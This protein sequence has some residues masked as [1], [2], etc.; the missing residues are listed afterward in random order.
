M[1]S[2]RFWPVLAAA[3][4][5]GS[6]FA[7]WP[8]A[9]GANSGGPAQSP[10][11]T[12]APVQPAVPHSAPNW[13]PP[14]PIA[15]AAASGAWTSLGP[16]PGVD[17]NAG[18]P[19]SNSSGRVTSIAV[20]PTSG[21]QTVFAG[22]AGGGVWK[23]TN[24][25]TSW[26][27]LTDTQ[28][29]MAI[30]ALAIDAT[31]QELFAGTGE[32]NFN[33]DALPSAGVL[34][35]TN[36]G[37]SWAA[38]G[39]GTFA[40][41]H[42][43]GLAIDRTTTGSTQ[44]VFAA[45]DGGLYQSSDGGLT[46]NPNTQLPTVLTGVSGNTPS[47][48]VFEIWQDPTTPT[49]FWAAAGD[50]CFTEQAAILKSTNS[51]AT[52]AVTTAFTG[53]G[54]RVAMGLSGAGGTT[55]IYAA[56]STCKGDLSGVV[57]SSNDGAT[58]TTVPA[59]APGLINYFN[60]SNAQ[61][62]YDN[63]VAVDPT[64]A[65]NAVFGGV[66]VLSTTNGGTSFTDIEHPYDN[67][68]GTTHN[69]NTHPDNH[70]AGFFAAGSFYLGNDGGMWKT[71]DMGGTGADTDWTNLNATLNTIQF[72]HGQALDSTDMLGGAQ[73]NGSL[74]LFPGGSTAPGWLEYGGGDGGWIGLPNASNYYV[75]TPGTIEKGAPS[76]P[77][78]NTVAAPC[79]DPQTKP[80]PACNEPADFTPPFIVDPS[81]ANRIITATNKVYESTTGGMPA[82]S[83]GWTAISPDLTAGGSD[84]ISNLA[85]NGNTILAASAAGKVQVSGN[86]GGSWSDVTAGLPSPSSA[87]AGQVMGN[88]HWI[89]GLALNPA[90]PAE[91][92]VGIQGVGVGHVWWTGNLGAGATWYDYS[93]SGSTG[94]ATSMPVLSMSYRHLTTSGALYV[95]TLN[96]VA[97]CTTCVGAGVTPSWTDPGTGLPNVAVFDV[98]V[99]ADGQSLMAWTHGRG[100]WSLQVGAPPPPPPSSVYQQVTP[101]RVWDTRASS[102]V[103]CPGGCTLGAGGSHVVQIT[104]MGTPAIP[105]NADAVAVNLTGI[106]PSTNTYLS[107]AP[108]GAPGLGSSSNLNLVSGAIQANLVTVALSTSGQVSVFNAQGT[109]DAAMDVQGYFVPSAAPPPAGTVGTFHPITP[110]RV[111]DTRVASS[112]CFGT[113]GAGQSRAVVVTAAAGGI[114]N[115]GSA[116]AAAF[117]LTAV[118]GTSGTY[119][120]ASPPNADGTCN[121]QTSSS[122]LN[123]N[124]GGI[125]PNRVIVPIGTLTANLGMVC[126]Y[127]A[128]GT[129]NFVIDT[130]GWFGSGRE[131]TVGA[132][133]YPVTPQ[134]ICDT[135]AGQGTQCQGR[136]IAAGQSLAVNGI[137][138]LAGDPTAPVA[139][140][141]NAT[142][143]LPTAGTF[144]SL[145]P[146]A[147]QPSP[148]TSDLNLNAGD[149]TAN[150][151]IVSL[152]G[153]QLDVY[154]AQGSIDVALDAE[155][156]FQ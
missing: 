36:G 96:G 60:L 52:W 91:A 8:Q 37:G 104:G 136:S 85:L 117:N 18:M 43:G 61:G 20:D 155:G 123:V 97:V 26:T 150:L 95:G 105:A 16:Q 88:G 22:T 152:A 114:P 141:V 7:V 23:S 24:G 79:S 71:T 12:P 82:G 1:G 118:Q 70:A 68:P 35:T 14:A 62:N 63:F 56:M 143:I 99:S 57:T 2:S 66:T 75:E 59:T 10:A 81:N 108:A 51:G 110:V 32:D 13:T 138:T 58:W 130:N 40:G 45:T 156:W 93:G 83:G 146:H 74:G 147:M 100:A 76:A 125:L 50:S 98:N 111:C 133:F 54:G 116:A 106:Q 107:V 11:R 124:A 34:K 80:D 109:A 132:L 29:S 49:T 53:G 3:L 55:T 145:Y 46:W 102:Q 137:G 151:A 15:P 87:G 142:G 89:G 122:S 78:M 144:V 5:V 64:N 148:L 41:K 128:A 73:D 94:I 126:I 86:N 42:I 30:G 4:I 92:W 31:G 112:P 21:G 115:D 67:V 47:G 131:A 153:G 65:M 44:V 103:N 48:G 127:N 101:F 134:R 25:G 27:A 39:S 9:A 19:Q 72:Y 77:L 140:I 120:T 6:G 90:N 139:V 121:P 69:G 129:V 33:A 28:P 119:L 113:L 149:I 38:E 154:N 17:L 84:Y 135:R